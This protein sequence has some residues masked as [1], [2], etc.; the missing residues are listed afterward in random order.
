MRGKSKLILMWQRSGLDIGFGQAGIGIKQ[1]NFCRT[2]P[3]LL[4]N[5]LNG[6]ARAADDG[7][8]HRHFGIHFNAMCH[9]GLSTRW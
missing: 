7:F 8:A 2:F 3:E 6:D 1:I 4:K 5:Q 9:H